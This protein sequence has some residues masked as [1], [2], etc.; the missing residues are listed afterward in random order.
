MNASDL[1]RIKLQ[2][3]VQQSAAATS[4]ANL[5]FADRVRIDV[6]KPPAGLCLSPEDSV[7]M[8]G[9]YT[10]R[11]ATALDQCDDAVMT[12]TSPQSQSRASKATVIRAGETVTFDRACWSALLTS[13]DIERSMISAQFARIA[14]MRCRLRLVHTLRK[15][16]PA[17]WWNDNRHLHNNKGESD[18]DSRVVLL[19][20]GVVHTLLS[21]L[22]MDAQ[23]PDLS[24]TE[25]SF[26]EKCVHQ[27]ADEEVVP[28]LARRPCAEA[29]HASNGSS[30]HGQ[31]EIRSLVQ[32]MRRMWPHVRPIITPVTRK[33]AGFALLPFIGIV[34]DACW[35]GIDTLA[36][37]A[38]CKAG[39]NTELVWQL[40][41]EGEPACRLIASR[42]LLPGTEL[43]CLTNTSLA[44]WMHI[45]AD[46]SRRHVTDPIN[47]SCRAIAWSRFH[48]EMAFQHCLGVSLQTC[49][50]VLCL[51]QPLLFP[52]ETSSD[53]AFEDDQHGR[54]AS[55]HQDLPDATRDSDHG[56]MAED[57]E[58]TPT[59]G[60]DL[61]EADAEPGESSRF[62]ALEAV[63]KAFEDSQVQIQHAFQT[64]AD[65]ITRIQLSHQL[66]TKRRLVAWRVGSEIL[67]CAYDL[68][69]ASRMQCLRFFISSPAPSV[70]AAGSPLFG[71]QWA[72]AACV[73]FA[74]CRENHPLDLRDSFAALVDG[75]M[76]QATH[77]MHECFSQACFCLMQYFHVMGPMQWLYEVRTVSAGA[78]RTAQTVTRMLMSHE[79]VV[80]KAWL[81]DSFE[82]EM[83]PATGWHWARQAALD[84][85]A[86][87]I[88]RPAEGPVL[89]FAKVTMD[90]A[91]QSN[92]PQQRGTDAGVDILQA[93]RLL[94]VA[95]NTRAD[96]SKRRRI[97][98]DS[99]CWR[100][101]GLLAGKINSSRSSGSQIWSGP[102]NQAGP[103]VNAS[104]FFGSVD[105][106]APEAVLAFVETSSSGP[107]TDSAEFDSQLHQ[108]STHM[109]VYAA[110]LPTSS[111]LTHNAHRE[112]VWQRDD[113]IAEACKEAIKYAQLG[114]ACAVDWNITAWRP[115]HDVR[116]RMFFSHSAGRPSSASAE[117]ERIRTAG[118]SASLQRLRWQLEAT[119]SVVF[120]PSLPGL[121]LLGWGV[122]VSSV[123]QQSARSLA[124][125]R[126]FSLTGSASVPTR[127]HTFILDDYPVGSAPPQLF[128]APGDFSALHK[129]GVSP[130]VLF[131]HGGD[132]EDS[133]VFLTDEFALA[134]VALSICP[135]RWHRLSSCIQ[136][137]KTTGVVDSA[138]SSGPEEKSVQLCAAAL[139]ED[140]KSD[141]VM[142]SL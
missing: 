5:L 107:K 71:L 131:S 20:E 110:F 102:N 18:G 123:A 65:E 93:R 121:P 104:I 36:D 28:N 95:S 4:S 16:D 10:L 116:R 96:S 35:A 34:R 57:R 129:I 89:P 11:L 139:A 84:S 100:D 14:E 125:G 76:A 37:S 63:L 79:D 83:H 60:T 15:V 108:L 132:R 2:E 130:L 135:S 19:E 21:L 66:A 97:D 74:E 41:N 105:T 142:Q 56:M 8:H 120:S 111:G 47:S 44:A 49:V 43:R 3:Y 27:A 39:A 12:A 17:V 119:G 6:W 91:G 138:T 31:E 78:Y 124:H 58:V 30:L 137:E 40:L 88:R 103:R 52:S 87:G 90:D 127:C 48:P 109:L 51:N 68:D 126:Q 86:A 25:L 136:G 33:M 94:S 50:C 134:C 67:Q 53:A 55:L 23:G 115:H 99:S 140:D 22:R 114:G 73:L 128:G 85:E 69:H 112:Y 72:W 80:H 24:D 64:T 54:G 59:H 82:H 101:S 141:H 122:C 38:P 7:R 29:P 117:A 113:A 61:A 42:V 70:A 133:A 98:D 92:H 62:F 81:L 1:D 118:V 32:D 26:L 106:G 13:E 46:Q 45:A 77:V 75:N 9:R